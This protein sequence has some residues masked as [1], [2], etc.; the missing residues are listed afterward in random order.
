MAEQNEGG[1]WFQN[2]VIYGVDI[3]TFFDSDGDGNGDFEGLRQKIGYF[4]EL[5][6]TCL[7]ILPFYPTPDRDNGYDITDYLAVRRRVGDLETFTRFVQEAKSHGIRV[8]TDL[9]MNHTSDQ[10][11]WF[12]ASRRSSHSRFRDYYVWTQ[13]PPTPKPDKGTIFPGEEETVWTWDETAGAFYHHRF[14]SH[15]P[16]LNLGNE[17]VQEE[18]KKAIDF[19]LCFGVDGMRVDAASHMIESR[20]LPGTAPDDPHG[21]LRDVRAWAS[22]HQRDVVLIG[23]ADEEPDRLASFFGNGDELNMLF[24]FVLNN[25]IFLA[26]ARQH[27]EPMQRVLEILPPVPARC[28]WANFL[29]NLDEVDLE[30]LT[31]DEL[32]EVWREFAPDEGMRIFGRGIRRRLAPML[33]DDR[34]RLEMA[35]SLL[36]SLPGAPVIM[37]G[38]EIAMGE[39]LDWPGREAVRGLMQWTAGRN[40]GFSTATAGKLVRK[41]IR[42]ERWGYRNRNVEKQ[43]ADPDSFL[44]WMRRLIRLRRSTP[45]IGTGQLQVVRIADERVFAHRIR[46]EGGSMFFVHNL[47]AKHASVPLDDLSRLDHD[48]QQIFPE[49]KKDDL[50]NGSIDLPPFGY[51]WFRARQG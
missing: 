40:G 50:A 11:P 23:E 5:G 21:L 46:H 17:L 12:Q 42:D 27:A 8:V 28:V 4:V 39:N 20:G 45:E 31:P 44:S 25:Y 38:D 22:E 9:V 18:L 1:V 10:H 43:L 14:Y 13:D 51:A 37:Y 47:S 48:L 34:R 29:R 33:T 6:V 41:P 15:E 24:N 36:F 3:D 26:L 49:G 32:D 7:W 35:W 19:W 16:S 2:A 30:R